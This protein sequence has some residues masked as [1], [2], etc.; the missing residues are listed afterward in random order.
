MLQEDKK[1]AQVMYLHFI[2]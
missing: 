2:Q 1:L